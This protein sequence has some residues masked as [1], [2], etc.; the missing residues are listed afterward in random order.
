MIAT[1]KQTEL[2]GICFW[3]QDRENR[4]LVGFIGG[5]STD[6]DFDPQRPNILAVILAVVKDLAAIFAD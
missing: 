1:T 6:R 2:L 3:R 4:G 5:M